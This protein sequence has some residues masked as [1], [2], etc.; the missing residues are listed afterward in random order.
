MLAVTSYRFNLGEHG[1]LS[2][3]NASTLVAAGAKTIELTF[4]L[5][6]AACLGQELTRRLT[7]KTCRGITMAEMQLKSFLS[8]PGSMLTNWPAVVEAG[9]SFLGVTTILAVF[10]AVLYTTASDALVSPRATMKS[11]YMLS[12]PATVRTG[13][14]NNT[15]VQS[16]CPSQVSQQE[17]PDALDTCDNIQ[18]TGYVFHNLMSYLNGFPINLSESQPELTSNR[19]SPLVIFDD[20]TNVQGQWM[21]GG[22][23]NDVVYQQGN[24]TVNNVTML[25]PHVGVVGATNGWGAALTPQDENVS[26]TAPFR[27]PVLC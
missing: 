1:S 16:S 3:Q 7:S 24:R 2:A 26:C 9:P 19:P 13:F 23:S 25:L 11:P 22:P 17:D 10:V 12:V 21:Q 6:C 5:V 27:L 14:V 8:Q 18:Q 4:V 20:V 15:Y